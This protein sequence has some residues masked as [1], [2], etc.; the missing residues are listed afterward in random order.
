MHPYIPSRPHCSNQ[1]TRFTSSTTSVMS[2]HHTITVHWTKQHGRKEDARVVKDRA[3]VNDFFFPLVLFFAKA[4]WIVFFLGGTDYDGYSCM[5][6]WD[7]LM[8]KNR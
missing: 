5:S 8:E 3:L 7:R 4:D 1:R 2:T 6:K